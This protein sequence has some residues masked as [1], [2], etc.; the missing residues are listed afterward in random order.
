[1]TFE[2]VMQRCSIKLL[3]CRSESSEKSGPDE[4]IAGPSNLVLDQ[5]S[6]DSAMEW[7]DKLSMHEDL[8]QEDM[9][10]QHLDFLN[11]FDDTEERYANF[12]KLNRTQFPS[13]LSSQRAYTPLKWPIHRKCMCCKVLVQFHVLR[14]GAPYAI[15][16]ACMRADHFTVVN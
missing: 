4:N 5:H 9:Q 7:A 10:R 14:Q 13:L 15:F 11:A 12:W 2:K 1:M 6:G 3:G 16:D 8:S